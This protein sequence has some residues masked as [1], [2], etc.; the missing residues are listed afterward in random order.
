MWLRH[1]IRF[2]HHVRT[3]A[4]WARGDYSLVCLHRLPNFI[5]TGTL[6]T[7]SYALTAK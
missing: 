5:R 7:S 1:L 4:A 2:W 6:K 3:K